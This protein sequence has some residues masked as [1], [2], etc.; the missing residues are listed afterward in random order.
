MTV[1]NDILHYVQK[2]CFGMT[3][4]SQICKKFTLTERQVTDQV[5]RIPHLSRKRGKE[6]DKVYF[7]RSIPDN[8]NPIVR[9]VKD[10]YGKCSNAQQLIGTYMYKTGRLMDVQSFYIIYDTYKHNFDFNITNRNNFFSTR[11]VVVQSFKAL[12]IIF[13]K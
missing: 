5:V 13:L 9:F 7:N 12:D 8:K 11:K 2:D 10:T 1:K 3:T 6:K 4:V